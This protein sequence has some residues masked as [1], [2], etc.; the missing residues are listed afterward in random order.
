MGITN[1]KISHVNAPGFENYFYAYVYCETIGY[2]YQS[3]NRLLVGKVF[4]TYGT[5]RHYMIQ[6]QAYLHFAHPRRACQMENI[7][8]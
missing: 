8:L 1:A 7:Y 2:F 6:C 4:I 5:L 3:N